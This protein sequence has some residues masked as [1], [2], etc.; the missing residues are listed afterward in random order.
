[1]VVTVA[2]ATSMWPFT[3]LFAVYESGQIPAA[4]PSGMVPESIARVVE[5]R[6]QG[7]ERETSR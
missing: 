5:S 2:L 7:P 4:W 6:F 1:M 3:Y